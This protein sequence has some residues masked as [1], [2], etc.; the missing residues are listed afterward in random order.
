MKQKLKDICAFFLTLAVIL[1]AVPTAAVQ[2][3]AADESSA[4]RVESILSK[5]TVRQKITQ[6][7]MPDFRKWD[8][9][10]SDG[11]NDEDFE[12]MN[13]QVA[14]I[15]EDY[16]FGGVILFANNVKETE[17]TFNLT[18]ALQG[19]A[20][21]DGGIPLLIG[22]D[23][24]GGS[25]YRL[26]SGTALPGNMALG[27][28]GNVENARLAGKVIGSELSALGINT[29]FAPSVDVNSNANNPVIGLRSFSDD[30]QLVAD[31]GVA[32]IEGMNEYGIASAAKH[33][34]GHGD[35][36][37]DSH[38][39]LP[40]VNKSLDELL[41]NELLPFQA[42]MDAGVDLIMTAHIM[43]PQLDSSTVYSEKTGQQEP[44]PATL[45]HA[46]LTDL[47]RDK[48]GYDG[49]II[50]DAMNMDA[51]AAMYDQVQATKLAIKAGVDIVLMPCSL[52]NNTE[53]LAEMDAII[54]GVEEAVE[55]G[56]ITEER[57][58]QSVRR[59]LTLKEK[60]GIL[61][62]NADSLSL[63][64]AEAVVGCDENRAIERELAA[65]AATVIKNENN[66]LPL[67]LTSSDKVLLLCPYSNE[68]AGLLI[69]WNRAKAAGLVP[70]GAEVQ[71]V[72][73][74][75]SASA[76][77][78]REYLDWAT[79][80]LVNSEVSSASAMMPAHWLTRVP[81]E[82]TDYCS[83]NGKKSVVFSVDKPYDVQ[84][85]A[86]ADAILAVYGCKGSTSD[87]TE[88]MG[89]FITAEDAAAGPN[90]TAAMEVSFGIFG[91]AGKLPVNV[92]EF[93]STAGTY[94]DTI[95]YPRGYG[96][97]YASVL[98]NKDKLS[99]EIS[100]MEQVGNENYTADS[101]DA[102][103]NALNKAK[104][105]LADESATQEDVDNVLAAL[106]DAYA[107]LT[108]NA[109]TSTEPAPGVQNPGTSADNKLGT[110]SDSSNESKVSA[111]KTGDTV[112]AMG[113]IGLTVV[114]GFAVLFL[115]SRKK[116]I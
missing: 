2:V 14:Q 65:E 51:V 80:V 75:S 112:N 81:T 66:T 18:Q 108:K 28:T 70:D 19:A 103:Q 63:E 57:L 41:T 94:T 105:V 73:Y 32:M 29:N 92:P 110:T 61:D 38:T 111:A 99:E 1:T 42:A 86:N 37:T 34:P 114:S 39:G 97:T 59:I 20:T 109:D 27:A 25:V 6:M 31:M 35:T 30:P 9:D 67:R 64:N 3:S 7:M 82:V 55:S 11:E 60:R 104:E 77:S 88:I 98:V 17:Q 96:L 62:Y 90:I 101:W 68:Q 52:Y 72:V 44:L 113:V 21:A 8:S 69:G 85:Y 24:E 10:L 15:L 56:E 40:V 43:F 93:D 50:T 78:L 95:V 49:V 83:E 33:F 71:V 46:I 13:D 87:P 54:Q 22:I 106:S 115:L 116:D 4:S 12:V 107:N 48:M 91:A 26:G 36:A 89:G 47:V 84:H 79:I 16:D 23:Q 53:D 5:M 102:F 74:N 100:S 58:D 76:E 45:S